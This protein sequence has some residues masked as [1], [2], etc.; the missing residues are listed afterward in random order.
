VWNCLSLLAQHGQAFT[1][2]PL[3]D[4]DFTKAKPLKPTLHLMGKRSVVGRLAALAL[5]GFVLCEIALSDTA[6]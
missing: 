2:L 1:L 4:L 5:N 6:V 3:L